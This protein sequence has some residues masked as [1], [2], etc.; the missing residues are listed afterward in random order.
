GRGRLLT[1]EIDGSTYVDNLE[2]LS[3]VFTIAQFFDSPCLLSSSH[4]LLFLPISS[5][6]GAMSYIISSASPLPIYFFSN[7]L[8]KP[9]ST[10]RKLASHIRLP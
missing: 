4:P 3:V 1:P 7:I 2:E 6:N 9:I 8:A 10:Y 5:K